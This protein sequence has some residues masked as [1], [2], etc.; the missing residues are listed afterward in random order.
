MA[1]TALKG[2]R[3]KRK[4]VRAK[5]RTGISYVPLTS[6]V[7]LTD[8]V[9]REVGKKEII[10]YNKAY[11]KKNL[12]KELLNADDWVF[13]KPTVTMTLLWKSTG[14][15]FPAGWD[16]ERALLK[17]KRDLQKYS[18]GTNQEAP[19]T[20]KVVMT[21]SPSDIIK[22]R[23]SNFI[24]GVEEKLD[25]WLD[26]ESYSVFDELKKV[27][28]PYIMAKSVKDFYSPLCNELTELVHEK[29]SDLLENYSHLNSKDQRRY[30]EFVSNIVSDSEKYM[31]TKKAARAIRKPKVKTADK[32]V[33]KLNYRKDSKEFKIASINPVLVVGSHRLFTFNV[34]Y[35][36][37]CELVSNS[38]KGF[39]VSGSTIKNVDNDESREITLRHPTRPGG[40]MLEVLS[41]TKKQID[42]FWSQ[43]STKTQKT[44]GR[45]NDNTILLRVMDK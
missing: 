16:S 26:N 14:Q 2:K 15:E 4:T 18:K 40:L 6:F 32:Q 3:S 43:Q 13:Y 39:E 27:D 17:F 28:A 38:V 22:D 7:G 37:L 31:S 30:L 36:K 25:Y 42:A 12:N 29:S 1:L 45:I 19:G 9:H 5:A 35:K 44:N 20:H 23:T 24:G 34:K 8:Y 41:K 11:V 21:R 10:N 33:A